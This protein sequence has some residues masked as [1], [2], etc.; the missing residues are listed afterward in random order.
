VI[1]KVVEG[2]KDIPEKDVIPPL[3][4]TEVETME[5]AENE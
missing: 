4:N 3:K 2:I 1:C 5:D